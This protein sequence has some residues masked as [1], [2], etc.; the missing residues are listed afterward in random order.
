MRFKIDGLDKLQRDLSQSKGILES[1]NTIRVTEF[2]PQ[3]PASVEAAIA[4]VRHAIDAK[5]GS[6]RDNPVVKPVV[7]ELKRKYEQ[8]ILARVAE[9]RLMNQQRSTGMDNVGDEL[10]QIENTILDLRSASYQTFDRHLTKLSR[11]IHS[12]ALDSVSRRLAATVDLEAVIAAGEKT[13]GSMVGSATLPG[14]DS[15]EQELGLVIGL[16]D[17]FAGDWNKA[18]Q[19][20]HTFYYAPGVGDTLHNL[21]AQ[22]FVPFLRD[23][24]KYVKKELGVA[25]TEKSPA[26]SA[27]YINI[28]NSSVGAVQT[29]SHSIANVTQTVNAEGTV[30][31]KEAL[32][33][34]AKAL[35]QVGT[36][37]GH[38][39]DDVLELIAD[40]KAELDKPKPNMSRLGSYLGTIGAVLST[41]ASLEPAYDAVKAAAGM[42]GYTLP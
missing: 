19:F 37:P 16:I 3:D 32:D 36:I 12:E 11:L 20:A 1:L 4:E 41:V 42:L 15:L 2:D 38:N 39:K 30:A 25:M 34:A 7:Q 21:V 29:G 28:Q 33:L 5:V 18:F 6:A 17:R 10:Q 14:L 22:M 8:K 27:T 24:S 40:G 31:L 9:A 26:G 35:A 13:Q 23:Y